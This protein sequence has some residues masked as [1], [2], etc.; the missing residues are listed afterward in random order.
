M[1]LSK[2][3]T[4]YASKLVVDYFSKF[5]RIDDYF[6][7]RKIERVKALPTPLFGMSVEDDMFQE[8]ELP[9]EEMNFQVTQMN[10]EIFD[11]MLE[12]TASFSPDEAPGKTLKLIVKETTTNK[13]V[14]F[15]K[16]G[17]PLIN[18]K[19]RNDFLGGVPDLGIFNKRAIM[20]FNIVPV[21][22]FGFNYLGGKLMAAICCSHDVRRMLDK[23]YDTEFC[24][25]ETTS[26][27]GNIKG[28]SMYDG[29]KPYLRYKGDTMSSFLLTMGEDIYFHLRDWF[30]EKNDGEPLIHKGASSRKLK[31]QTKMI[32]IIKASLKE[33][34]TKGYELFCDVINKSTDVTTQK[35]FYMSQYGYSN[36]R[37]VLLGKTDKLQKAENYDRFELPEIIKWWKKL[38]TKRHNNLMSDGRIRK[39]LEVWNHDTIDK[40]DII[41]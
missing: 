18:S 25:F 6:R 23:K 2:E 24:L 19:P 21:Q 9:P 7:A 38:A 27:Y 16:M 41:R 5:G 8:W 32:Q 35:R 11:Q 39:E 37:D 28:A 1:I 40:I 34:D 26:L 10:N 17:S 14:G 31:Y 33:H 30:E 29:M 4:I 15:I 13:A 20:G 22:P 12:M 3:D 36:T